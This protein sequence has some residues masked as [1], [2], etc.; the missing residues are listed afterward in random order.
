MKQR[1]QKIVVEEP[2]GETVDAPPAAVV[3]E[4]TPAA[5][6]ATAADDKVAS[7]ALPDLFG[8]KVSPVL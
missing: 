6:A 7:H 3:T 1:W 4:M 2:N 8:A 5:A